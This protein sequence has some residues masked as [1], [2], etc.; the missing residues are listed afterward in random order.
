MARKRP[1]PSADDL[2]Q[3]V[4][5]RNDRAEQQVLDDG[6][7]VLTVP[8]KK[9]W[10]MGP[11]LSWFMPIRNERRF[12]LDALGAEVWDLC[13]NRRDMEQII[14]TFADRH[15]LTF[16]EARLSVSAFLRTLVERGCI[17]MAIPDKAVKR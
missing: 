4:P 8:L 16:H 12:E 3:S 9:T 14:E 5:V 17:V 2:L 6:K 15:Q 10:F 1:K 13:N 7:V 11:P